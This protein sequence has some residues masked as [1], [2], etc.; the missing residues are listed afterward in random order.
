MRRTAG[1]AASS[2][3]RAPRR[4]DPLADAAER[5]RRT[6]L[7]ALPR[8]APLAAYV[9]DLRRRAPGGFVPDFDPE[10]GGAGAGVLILL[11][12]PGPKAVAHGFVSR[13]QP[14]QTA[15]ALRE[16]LAAARLPRTATALWNVVP[17]YAPVRR[18]MT[19]GEIA[20]GSRLLADILP[21]FPRLRVIVTLGAIARRG[22]A[23]LPPPAP[24]IAA[25]HPSPNNLAARPAD[26]ARIAAAFAEARAVLEGRTSAADPSRL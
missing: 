20:E 7:L 10:D 15:R 16:A 19:T 22:L 3:A 25:P 14:S 11:Q 2:P 1:S 6:A 18:H 4:A 21:L 5:D 24:I 17:W 12:R 9:E 8:M 26:R 23:L 13:D